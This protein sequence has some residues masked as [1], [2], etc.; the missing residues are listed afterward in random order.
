MANLN[1]FQ[2]FHTSVAAWNQWR[3][4]QA[5]VRP[6]LSGADLGFSPLYDIDDP[7]SNYLSNINFRITNLRNSSL[8]DICFIGS[9][10]SFADLTDAYLE[11]SDLSRALFFSA[12]LISTR[13]NHCDMNGA[14]FSGAIIGNLQ[15]VGIDFSLALGLGKMIHRAISTIDKLSIQKTAKGLV[16]NGKG[17]EGVER[18]LSAS[19]NAELVG[20]LRA[21]MRRFRNPCTLICPI[22]VDPESNTG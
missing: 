8:V 7:Y 9:D 13:F 5:T 6:D 21:E 14:D 18:F 4:E 19:G 22:S 16:K 10:F 12:T 15:L 2:T 1:H 20:E 17:I 3:R 11:T